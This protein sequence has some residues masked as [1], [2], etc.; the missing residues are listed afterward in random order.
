MLYQESNNYDS[1][2]DSPTSPF[3]KINKFGG[4]NSIESPQKK[5]EHK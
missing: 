2:P 1:E 3:W 4:G 5:K